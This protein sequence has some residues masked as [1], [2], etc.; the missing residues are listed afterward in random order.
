MTTQT[1]VG[2]KT[3]EVEMTPLADAAVQGNM[4]IIEKLVDYRAE[5]NIVGQV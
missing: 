4:N 1:L 2:G 3:E 5:V